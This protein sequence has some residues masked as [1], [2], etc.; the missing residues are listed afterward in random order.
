MK[1][2]NLSNEL[3]DKGLLKPY[4]CIN[5][6]YENTIRNKMNRDSDV[7]ITHNIAPTLTTRSD[8]LG[9]CMENKV[10]LVGGG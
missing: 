6:T 7:A 3:L 4:D 8:C 1:K 9:V 10:R 2:I 5:I